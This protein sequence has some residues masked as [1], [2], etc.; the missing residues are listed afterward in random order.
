MSLLDVPKRHG[1]TKEKS[2]LQERDLAKRLKGLVT[3][4]SGAGYIKGDV[5]TLGTNQGVYDLPNAEMVEAKTTA[6]TQFTVKLQE[7]VKLERE[8]A[9]SG[10]RPLF[11]IQL[12][13]TNL[14]QFDSN[15]W[16]LLPMRHYE[17]LR[18][19]ERAEND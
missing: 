8:A 12:D 4:G 13:D 7:L 11:V 15:E 18:E 3:P 17:V 2:T 9:E 16:V 6:K 1:T 19:R 10:R 5:T 14:R